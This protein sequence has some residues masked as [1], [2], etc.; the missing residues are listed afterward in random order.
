MWPP[1]FREKMISIRLVR[2]RDS[3]NGL[4]LSPARGVLLMICS[5]KAKYKKTGQD[6]DSKRPPLLPCIRFALASA[7]GDAGEVPSTHRRHGRAPGG[8]GAH[9][10][11]LVAV[12]LVHQVQRA[13]ARAVDQVAQA[14]TEL[15]RAGL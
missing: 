1:D 3:P 5:A 4:A 13:R 8:E 12:L 2:C 11:N 10:I 6:Q 7:R 9:G 15:H 14:G